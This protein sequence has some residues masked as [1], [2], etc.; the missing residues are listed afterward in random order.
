MEV[1]GDKTE[2]EILY[3]RIRRRREYRE[4]KNKIRD[5]GE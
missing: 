3:K 1:G 5:C 2:M 4:K